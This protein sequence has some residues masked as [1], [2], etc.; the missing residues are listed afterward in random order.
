MF[1]G[2]GISHR[3]HI[4]LS[5]INSVKQNAQMRLIIVEFNGS[6]LHIYENICAVQRYKILDDKTSNRILDINLNNNIRTY[7]SKYFLGKVK[8]V[9]DLLKY[10]NRT[11]FFCL[12]FVV[13]MSLL[14]FIWSPIFLEYSVKIYSISNFKIISNV[15]HHR[16]ARHCLS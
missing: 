10:L 12:K 5:I 9:A 11:I 6:L 3:N 7:F 14:Y 8:S 16:N 1:V 4:Q 15:I 2:F 13:E